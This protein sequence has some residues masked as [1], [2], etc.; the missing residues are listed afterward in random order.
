[1]QTKVHIKNTL[2]RNFSDYDD[3]YLY[4]L[5]NKKREEDKKENQE[6]KQ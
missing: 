2:Y 1:M 5:K 6:T 4:D 3:S